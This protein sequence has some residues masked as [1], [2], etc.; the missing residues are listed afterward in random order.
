MREGVSVLIC[1]HNGAERIKQTLD[2]LSNQRVS[3]SFPWEIILV[4]NASTDGTAQIARSS[5]KS[6]IPLS[7]IFEKNL[8]V[9]NAR[10]TGM[11][12]CHYSYIGFIDDDNWADENWVE[13]A[14][15]SMEAN[16]NA[17]AV[18]GPSEGVF[19]SPPPDWFF[20]YAKN[21]AIG[22]QYK[23]SG[24]IQKPGGLLW[25]AGMVIRKEIWDYLYQFG[26]T[27]LLESR[28]GKK[29]MSGEESEILIL[30]KLMG[31][32]LVY[33]PNLKIQHYMPSPR[34]QWRYY[35]K[36]RISL[37]AS[38]VY[39]GIYKDVMNSIQ[40]GAISHTK[41]WT[42]EIYQTLI[43]IVKDPFGLLA[44]LINIKKGNFRIATAYFNIG[45]LG[46]QIKLGR[47]IKPLHH[48]LYK[49]YLPLKSVHKKL[50]GKNT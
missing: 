14:Y 16:P 12:A 37:G 42:S 47:K 9:A 20:K 41:S 26:F 48:F 30:A 43:E 46:Q 32:S 21:Y 29:L 28:K 8:G 34:L 7:I 44:S 6:E 49:K 40:K 31:W 5:W 18:G 4:D 19:E 24:K 35:R 39:L 38:S 17:G 45:R 33:E 11:N 36:L 2:H 15:T 3:K 10:K 27:P 1:T 50:N 23:Q 22:N 25:G 13:T